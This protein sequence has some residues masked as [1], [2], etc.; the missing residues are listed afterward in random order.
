MRSV[1]LVPEGSLTARGLELAR[2][3][4]RWWLAE[5][6][7]LY[8]G[9]LAR[10]MQDT[11]AGPVLRLG[12]PAIDVL[13]DAADPGSC[14][15]SF[16]GDGAVRQAAAWLDANGLA[17]AGVIG[18]V[19]LSRC[20]VRPIKLPGV[21]REDVVGL[22]ELDLGHTTPFKPGSVLWTFVDDS[23]AGS[24]GVRDVRQ[25][26]IHRD[27]VD[28]PLADAAQ[29]GLIVTAVHVVDDVTGHLIGHNLLPAT[30][31]TEPK[32]MR[33][34]VWLWPVLAAALCAAIWVDF[35]R[36]NEALS[37][38]H[39]ALD[40]ART[41]Y[42]AFDT[43]QRRLEARSAAFGELARLAHADLRVSEI[44]REITRLLPDSAWLTD[45]RLSADKVELSGF[46]TGAATL[47]DAFSAASRFS[48]VAF[49]A[50]VMRDDREGKEHFVISL[51][52]RRPK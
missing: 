15:A 3:V 27:L 32:R 41:K 51:R 45:M 2:A 52:I 10:S 9:R 39:G 36:Q 40:A 50:P 46:A 5:L 33:F 42:H 28:H 19:P 25:I 30:G 37:K 14:L 26:I 43:S 34:A 38:L 6:I 31:P 48:D 16:T 47:I 22:L 17:A 4:W 21:A 49:A 13:G 12:D 44:L 1:Q 20:L 8:P 7:A 24:H 11:K 35:A 23:A 29:Q 18:V